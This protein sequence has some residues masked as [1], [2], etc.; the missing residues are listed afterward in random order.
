MFYVIQQG[1]YDGDEFELLV[2]ILKRLDLP[3]VTVRVRADGRLWEVGTA[4]DAP[5]PQLPSDTPIFVLGTYA[6]AR[7]ARARG[8]FPGALDSDPLNFSACK[9]GWGDAMLNAQAQLLPLGEIPPQIAPVFLRPHE[10]SKAFNGG[11]Q[12]PD[13]VRALQEKAIVSPTAHFH[14][15]TLV[16]MAPTQQVLREH[17]FFV[18]GRQVVTGSL[19]RQGTLW[20]TRAEVDDDARQFAQA[21]VD[22]WSP[23][24]HFVLDVA[25]TP[26]GHRIVEVNGLNMA[27]LYASNPGT[28]VM[29]LEDW[30]AA[31]PEGP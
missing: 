12:S 14:P 18:V 4:V 20:C 3:H 8:W 11:V 27:G 13:E 25:L 29:A 5:E 24:P 19:Y 22:R 23:L 17:R 7:V 15:Q 21:C 2:H 10:D 1:L 28:L 26:Q 16:V 6:L 31:H 9:E 30:Y